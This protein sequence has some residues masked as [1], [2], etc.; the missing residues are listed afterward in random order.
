MNK[1]LKRKIFG[2]ASLA[3]VKL[4]HETMLRAQMSTIAPAINRGDSG[5]QKENQMA[6]MGFE[7]TNVD[8]GEAYPGYD[9]QYPVPAGYNAPG[10]DYG[11][12]D[13]WMWGGGDLYAYAQQG[14][15]LAVKVPKAKVVP[16]AYK[17][18]AALS[19]KSKNYRNSVL[20]SGLNNGWI[21]IAQCVGNNFDTCTYKVV[22][23]AA[24][25]SY[26]MNAVS[27]AQYVLSKLSA[28]QYPVQ[29]QTQI[30]AQYPYGWPGYA[31][32]Q[33]L[34]GLGAPGPRGMARRPRGGGRR[35]G[36]GGG[37][38]GPPMI[39]E[40]EPMIVG[41]DVSGQCPLRECIEAGG[42]WTENEMGGQC[43]KQ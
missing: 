39:I 12:D 40:T 25:Y 14:L 9:S 3:L 15:P 41:S 27:A 20:R 4:A 42:T 26:A 29:P 2:V 22:G 6:G 5:T 23:S 43:S 24:G 8:T 18:R 17:Q 38:W 16:A 13:S 10:Q 28:P 19:L 32:G 33:Q 34:F 31:A 30:Q 37:Y 7:I 11:S 21:Q 35:G 1:S 36:W